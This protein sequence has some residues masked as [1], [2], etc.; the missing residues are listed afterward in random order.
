LFV[1][2]VEVLPQWKQINLG[3]IAGKINTIEVNGSNILAGTNSGIN[4]STNYGATWERVNDKLTLCFAAIGSNVFAGTGNGVIISSDFGN[5]WTIPNDSMSYYITALAIKDTVIFAGTMQ[6]GIFRSINKGISWKAVDSG[7]GNF[8][9]MINALALNGNMVFA[10]TAAGLCVSTNNGNNWIT[11]EGNNLYANTYINCIATNGAT[12]F[13]GTPSNILRSTD[14]GNTWETAYTGLNN[15]T[16]IFSFL[17][18]NPNVF[19]GTTAGVYMSTDNGNDWT[20]VSNGLP[21]S[22]PSIFCCIR[23]KQ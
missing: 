1:S 8:Q 22:Q 15:G 13:A 23:T 16:S 5:N 12:V 4:R 11:L 2:V 6:N 20:S 3:P 10:G 19:A 21:V 7:L 17:L 18:N 9:N 14:N